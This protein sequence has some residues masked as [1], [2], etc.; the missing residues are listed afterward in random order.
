MKSYGEFCAL[1]RALDVI[2]DRWTMLVVRELLIS[3]SRYSDLQRSL[4]GIATNLLAQRLRSLEEAGVVTSR[5]EPAP[6]AARVYSLTAWGREL[7][8]PLV[9]IARW[10]APL[11]EVEDTEK[12][13]RGRWLVF[14]VM[15][16]YPDAFASDRPGPELTARIDI[17]GDTLL[18]V[19][20]GDGVSVSVVD[21]TVSAE[22][23][24]DGSLDEVFRLLSGE[25]T[26]LPRA[27]VAGDADAR[28]RLAQLISH[29]FTHGYG[30]GEFRG[31]THGPGAHPVS[32]Q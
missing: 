19:A 31:E 10:G 27:R 30:L 18:L 1:S 7:R 11:M 13:S 4:P 6:V 25:R 14:A 2:G 26:D 8:R 5:E 21:T 28:D 20:T 15:A 29:A 12:H 23:L 9:A 17:D 22:L 32:A 16:L 3:P 24:I